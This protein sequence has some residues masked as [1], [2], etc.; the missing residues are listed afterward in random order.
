MYFKD[1]VGQAYDNGSNMAREY[2]NDVQAI[3][4]GENEDCICFGYANH[5]H[6][7]CWMLQWNYNIICNRA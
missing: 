7:L 6:I 1:S 4:Y 3:K 5:V 2:Y